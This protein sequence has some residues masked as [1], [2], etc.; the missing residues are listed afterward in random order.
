M[1]LRLQGAGVRTCV[2][3]VSRTGGR[4]L[5]GE[6]TLS[7]DIPSIYG[8][9]RDIHLSAAYHEKGSLRG[10]LQRTSRKSVINLRETE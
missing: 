5:L 8:R 1:L 4:C 2:L 10:K 3:Q 6:T 7:I 9:G